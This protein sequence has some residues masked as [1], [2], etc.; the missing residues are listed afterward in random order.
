LPSNREIISRRRWIAMAEETRELAEDV[1]H[2][3]PPV[4]IYE[5]TN[6]VILIA[7]VP[8]VS[9]K[10]LQLDIDKDELTIKGVFEE[11]ETDGQKLVD[12]CIYGEYNRT[13][14]LGDTIDREK[15]SAK[16]EDGVLTLTLPKREEVKPRKITV[17][18][19]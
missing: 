10:N 5:T 13:F 11:K 8:G 19:E 18:T 16:L 6:D 15:I 7:D 17:E 9:K 4:D 1:R 2:I 12:E 3:I 14:A